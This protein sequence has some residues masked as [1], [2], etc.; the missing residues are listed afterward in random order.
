MNSITTSAATTTPSLHPT[1]VQAPTPGMTKEAEETEGGGGGPTL[2][3]LVPL[4]LFALPPATGP[5]N[6]TTPYYDRLRTTVSHLYRGYEVP[7][8]EARVDTLDDGL[9]RARYLAEG[10]VRVW[11]Y[12]ARG[13]GEAPATVNHAPCR[14][15]AALPGVVQ[16]ATH[17]EA[18]PA[19]ALNRVARAA[20]RMLCEMADVAA[21]GAGEEAA[22]PR[23]LLEG[24]AAGRA[25]CGPDC[26]AL[27]GTTEATTSAQ[28]RL[29]RSCRSRGATTPPRYAPLVQ[30]G[31]VE[32]TVCVDVGVGAGAGVGVGDGET[33]ERQ[34]S[35]Q[36]GVHRGI[37][38]C[39]FYA[40]KEAVAEEV[41]GKLFP[42][43]AAVSHTYAVTGPPTTTEEPS[44]DSP[45]TSRDPSS[46]CSDPRVS[47]H[48]AASAE[49]AQLRL[50]IA[51]I[52]PVT[53]STP[54]S[55]SRDPSLEP[56]EVARI[57]Q[58]RPPATPGYG[59]REW[60][61]S[62]SS[63]SSS[64]G[65]SHHR[66]GPSSR[67]S[68]H[69]RRNDDT[70]HDRRDRS[71]D[72]RPHL[73]YHD[74]TDTRRSR[75]RIDY[76]THKRPLSPSARD[77]YSISTGD[78]RPRSRYD[79]RPSPRPYPSSG[80]KRYKYDDRPSVAAPARP[81]SKVWTRP[82]PQ[83]SPE[84]PTERPTRVSRFYVGRDR[85]PAGEFALCVDEHGL[86][87]YKPM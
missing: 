16:W 34:Q 65:S 7:R 51:S 59:R 75:D 64:A 36:R 44:V 42:E 62:S 53:H 48:A 46:K 63:N 61:R 27:G 11:T 57:T 45:S 60:S 69:D 52:S 32:A 54:S 76:P 29:F 81:P 55:S 30:G 58:R 39:C 3:D 37:V 4:S 40:A 12:E 47:R 8:L 5:R 20:S 85:L 49:A 18:S 82:V 14:S 38:A 78:D 17:A 71:R 72:P 13:A 31:A 77:R 73:T 86:E 50:R 15:L 35:Q 6:A 43:E 74:R 24:C 21:G 19:A 41:L 9:V 56:G 23:P 83:A 22:V 66:G 79:D 84:A 25:P 68:G 67:D 33:E 1:A 2:L 28:L 10:A 26:D 80:S 87:Y 70:H